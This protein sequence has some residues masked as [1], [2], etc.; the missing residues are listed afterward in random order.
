MK[1]QICN[2]FVLLLASLIFLVGAGV[3]IFDL[4]CSNCVSNVFSMNAYEVDCNIVDNAG[5]KNKSCC[6]DP[7]KLAQDHVTELSHCTNEHEGNCCEVKRIS[8]DIDSRMQQFDLSNST[9]L[10][11][12]YCY[13]CSL[14]YAAASAYNSS[15]SIDKKITP[16]PP[17]D[18]L[19]LIQVLII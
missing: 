13:C 19:S 14:S 17:R 3:T 7:T 4:C 5:A 6:S 12:L 18:Y 8:V 2:L 15:L 10:D 1:K 9:T 11:F 16:I